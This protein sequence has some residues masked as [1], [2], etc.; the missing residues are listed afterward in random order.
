M[1]P[2]GQRHHQ[3]LPTSSQQDVKPHARAGRCEATGTQPSY[4][5][6]ELG[7][8]QAMTQ[9]RRINLLAVTAGASRASERREQMDSQSG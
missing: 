3:L 1:H 9:G 2:K 8:N 6:G 5:D 7:A 4:V